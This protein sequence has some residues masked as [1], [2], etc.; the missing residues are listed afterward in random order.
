[1][2][3]RGIVHLA[4]SDDPIPSARPRKTPPCPCC[5]LE[6]GFCTP[7]RELLAGFRVELFGDKGTFGQRSDQR[8]YKRPK[9][10]LPDCDGFRPRGETYCAE[11]QH[12]EDEE[13]A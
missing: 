11:H 9:C 2:P 1:M 13:A 12:L 6:G 10:R 8:G 4:D 3:K 7:H 5:G